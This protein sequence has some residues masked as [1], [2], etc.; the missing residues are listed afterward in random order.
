MPK[1]QTAYPSVDELSIEFPA[2]SSKRDPEID[3]SHK[4]LSV[5]TQKQQ[6]S[7]QKKLNPQLFEI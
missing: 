1:T 6:P 3:R 5:E 4:K 7:F 2:D